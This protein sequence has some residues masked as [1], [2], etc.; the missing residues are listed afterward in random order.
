MNGG[1]VTACLLAALLA[2]GAARVARADCGDGRPLTGV[3]L[4]GAEFNSSR[5]PGVMNKDYT[6]PTREELVYW[7]GKGATAIRLPFR[8]ERL[9]DPLMGTPDEAQLAAIKKVADAAADL[10]LCLILDLHNYGSYRGEALD[11]ASV[12]EAAFIDVWQRLAQRFPDAR[13]VALA[14]MNEPKS[15]PIAQWARVAQNTVLKLRESG[16]QHLILVSGG[17]FSGVHEWSKLLS[18]TSN[19]MAFADFQDPAGRLAIE[20]HQYADANFSG[21]GTT[22]L[23]PERF[24]DMFRIASDWARQTGHKLF[25]GEFGVPANPDCLAALDRIL[26]LTRDRGTWLGWTY[27]AAGRWWGGYPLSIAPRADGSDA[28]QMAVVARYLGQ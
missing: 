16:S 12:P 22:C 23:A 11:S 9:Q 4:A 2:W 14:L 20:M 15:L 24:D 25:L 6:Y 21:T 3:N 19:A 18:G 28:P 7:A 26:S 10:N 27:W 17:R 8:W 5:L 13:H 1:W